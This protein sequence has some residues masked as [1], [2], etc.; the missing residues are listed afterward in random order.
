MAATP[1]YSLFFGTFIHLPRQTSLNGPHTLEINH[2]VLWVSS[3]DGKI[4]G[5]NWDVRNEDDLR[6]F[7]A[8]RKWGNDRITVIRAREERNEFFFPGFIGIPFLMPI[9]WNEKIAK[10][11]RYAYSRPAI[12]KLRDLRLLDVTRLVTNVYFSAGKIVRR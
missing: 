9:L 2:G 6:E 7:L 11:T 8:G 3:E 12:P 1:L 10:K 4:K 5:Y